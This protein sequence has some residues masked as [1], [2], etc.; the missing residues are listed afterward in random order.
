V[1]KAFIFGERALVE[2]PCRWGDSATTL[3]PRSAD[4][5]LRR[6][7]WMPENPV[8]MCL[9]SRGTVLDVSRVLIPNPGAT[10]SNRVGGIDWGQIAVY[11]SIQV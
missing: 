7:T 10:R 2:C 8:V 3:L 1:V 5:R 6:L 11:A 4:V 9:R